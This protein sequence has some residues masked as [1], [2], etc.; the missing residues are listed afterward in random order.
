[1]VMEVAPHGCFDQPG[2]G[3][4]VFLRQQI[5]VVGGQAGG[6]DNNLG[7]GRTVAVMLAQIQHDVAHRHLHE[8]RQIGLEAVLEIDLEAEKFDVKFPGFG[9][10]ENSQGR[11]DP[12]KPCCHDM[13]RR[14]TKA[15]AARRF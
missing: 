15:P 3:I 13:P 14:L 4:A 11:N 1:M 12:R 9:A 8:Q 6:F 5:G 10:I 2:A 7:T